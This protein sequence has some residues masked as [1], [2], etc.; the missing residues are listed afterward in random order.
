[1][2][3][4][5]AL[6]LLTLLAT[7]TLAGQAEAQSIASPYRF[8]EKKKDVGIFI[9]YM[10]AD[11]GSAGLG[12]AA[13]PIAGAEFNVRVSDPITIGFYGA[14]FPSERDVIDPQ[15]DDESERIVG[16]AD[17]N[18]M[19]LAGRLKLQLTGSRTWHR[20]VPYVYGGLGLV[21]NVSGGPSCFAEPSQTNCQVPARERLDFGTSFLGQI[22]VGVIWLPRE[23]LGL[24]VTFDD[25]IWKLNTPDG[26]YDE[27]STLF[28]VPPRSDWT[29]NLQLTA[30]LYFWF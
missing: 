22:G 5:H 14:Y 6:F 20:L 12:P 13:G 8:V 17:M 16:T 11:Q 19:L 15:A 24:R 1:M 29:N 25:S 10:F 3:K 7:P 27:T 2:Q 26:F 4:R 9:G 28:P 30:G 23:R 21:F 18:L